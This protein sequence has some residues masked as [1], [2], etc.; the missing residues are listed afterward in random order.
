MFSHHWISQ[1]E[2]EENVLICLRI[3]IELHKQFRP[4]ISQEVSTSGLVSACSKSVC[5]FI[6]MAYILA[7]LKLFID[8][9]FLLRKGEFSTSSLILSCQIHHFLDFV[10]QIYKDLSKV[11]V[12]TTPHNVFV[13]M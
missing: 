5:V 13:L 3:I 2:S 1:I 10:K 12:S 4:P 8:N 11:V 7:D 9:S 6:K